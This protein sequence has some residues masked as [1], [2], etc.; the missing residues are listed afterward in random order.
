MMLKKVFCIGL[1]GIGVSAVA[2]YYAAHGSQ[3]FGS[4]AFPSPVITDAVKS[5]VTYVGPDND[6]AHISDDI[7][8]VIYT[9]ACPP[10]HPELVAAKT[11]SIKTQAFVQALGD[12]MASSQIRVA[13]SGTNGKSTTT[14]MTAMLLIDAGLDPTVFVGSRVTNFD[15][16]LRLGQSQTFVAEADE[17]RNHFHALHPSVLTITNIEHDHPDF[18]PDLSSVIKSFET[19]VQKLPPVGILVL[20]IDD[21]NV[22]RWQEDARAVTVSASQAADLHY[23]IEQA[24]PSEQIWRASWRGQL[25]GPFKL[26]IPGAHNVANAACA[27]ATALAVG[28][29]PKHAAKTFDNFLGI[30]RRFEV[31]RRNAPT[32]IND[33]AHHPTAIAATLQAARD[34]YPGRRIVAAFQPHHHQRLTVLYSEFVQSFMGADVV[35]IDEVYAV[36]GRENVAGMKTSQDLVNDIEKMGKQVRYAKNSDDT[37]TIIT[38]IMQ[39]DDV[40]LVMGAGDIWEIAEKIG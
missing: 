16:N 3:V 18:F 9:D 40:I 6:P 23:S 8:L 39:S 5:G 27:L 1:G 13:I 20:N 12:I 32:V 30:W 24:G 34:F 15:G 2:K 7:N 21:P 26:H 35:I 14:A 37:L 10:N 28:A 19:M 38:S 22:R 4:D 17:W 29:D 31:I 11:K 33:Y 36:L 25:L